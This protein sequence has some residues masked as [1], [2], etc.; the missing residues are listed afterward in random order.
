MV[1]LLPS[2]LSSEVSMAMPKNWYNSR[3]LQA[4]GAGCTDG[5][6]QRSACQGET[7]S[8]SAIGG[9]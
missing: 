2:L 3:E 5:G 6:W 7:E 8:A 9:V 4:V 1:R